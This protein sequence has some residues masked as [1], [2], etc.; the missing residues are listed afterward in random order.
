MKRK[1]ML[2]ALF[3]L[4]LSMPALAK[5]RAASHDAPMA[6]LTASYNVQQSDIQSLRDKG[7]SWNDV[8]TALAISKRTGQAVQELVAQ[9]DS[10]MEWNELAEKNGFKLSEIRGEPRQVAKDFRRADGDYRR[11]A[12]QTEAP[13][14]SEPE[15]TGTSSPV[16]A[17]DNP[18]VTPGEIP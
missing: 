18:S 3:G 8:G 4:A 12:I 5:D 14:P 9:K 13:M 16:D 1:S 2:A 17:S 6:D 10:G 15:R 7:W 11:E